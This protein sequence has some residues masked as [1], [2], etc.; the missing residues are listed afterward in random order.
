VIASCVT[1]GYATPQLEAHIEG[2]LELGATPA[3]IVEVILQMLFY[4]GG[5]ATS[6]ALR[7]AGE[8]FARRGL[9]VRPI[10]ATEARWG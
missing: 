10:A 8:I 1:L 7:L 4:A 2:A 3:Q 9:P 5:A 6:N